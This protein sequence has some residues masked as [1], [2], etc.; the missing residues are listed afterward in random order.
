MNRRQFITESA[1]ALAASYTTGAPPKKTSKAVQNGFGKTP[2]KMYI[3]AVGVETYRYGIKSLP[4]P[5]LDVANIIKSFSGN[6]GE[7]V[8]LVNG[9]KEGDFLAPTKRNIE[10]AVALMAKKVGPHDTFWFYYSGHG[11]SLQEK[12]YLVPEDARVGVN[13]ASTLISVSSIRK[14][15][16]NTPARCKML[17]LDSCHA[18][19]AKGI[20]SGTSGWEDVT[21]SAS[22]VVTM[23]ACQIDQNAIDTG[24]G[25]LFTNYLLVG[26]LGAALVGKDKFIT[27]ANLENFVKKEVNQ[28][29]LGKQTPVFIYKVSGDTLVTRT[30]ST[31]IEHL[32]SLEGQTLFV[33][34]P[35]EPGLIIWID[36]EHTD[37]D[38]NIERETIM[39]PMLQALFI[40]DGFPILIEDEARNF[41]VHLTEPEVAK[42]QKTISHLNS[43][44]LLRGTVKIKPIPRRFDI[45]ADFES[46]QAQVVVQLVDSEG[47]NIGTS[48]ALETGRGVSQASAIKMALERAVS[49]IH[50]DIYS[51]VSRVL[52]VTK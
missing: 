49:K 15:L 35:L 25:S 40:A 4:S 37:T 32:P 14:V 26:I 6:D 8:V 21:N 9:I 23:A 30:N 16:Q 33:R 44:F 2:G 41:R 12:S 22:G 45:Q 52:T 31:P 50:Q 18:G 24:T 51:K 5:R 3:V 7:V 46:V 10:Q 39:Q 42:V 17:V 27:V 38:G 36:E 20:N 28:T 19:S 47:G 34:R 29:S 48:I 11:T 1:F 13:M 43:R